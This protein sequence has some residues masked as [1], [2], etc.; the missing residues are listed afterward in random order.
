MKSFRTLKA[1]LCLLVCMLVFAA[2]AWASEQDYA[3]YYDD[4]RGCAV[5]NSYTGSETHV[6]VPDTVGGHTVL[7]VSYGVFAGNT[8]IISV[9]LPESVRYLDGGAFAACTSLETVY[10]PEN[11][12]EFNNSGESGFKYLVD[13]D[14][15]TAKLMLNAAGFYPGNRFVDPEYP[16]MKLYYTANATTGAAELGLYKYLAKDEETV[17]VPD[18]VMHIYDQAFIPEDYSQNT[19]LKEIHLPDS[20]VSIGS[21]VFPGYELPSLENIYLS[22]NISSW[23]AYPFNGHFSLR[24]YCSLYSTTARTFPNDGTGPSG[25]IDPA[26]PDFAWKSDGSG[27]RILARYYGSAKSLTIPDDVTAIGD[28]AFSSNT[29]LTTITVPDSVTSVGMGAFFFDFPLEQN[30]QGK[31]TLYLPDHITSIEVNSLDCGQT[32]LFVNHDSATAKELMRHNEE[33]GWG[34]L[35]PFYDPQYPDYLLGQLNNETYFLG[36]HGGKTDICIP[37]ICTVVQ[38]NLNENTPDWRNIR[39]VAIS[40]GVTRIEDHA[41]D[42]GWSFEFLSLPSTL[43]YIGSKALFA[44]SVRTLI[45]P[46]GVT[47][48]GEVV[49]DSALTHLVLPASLTKIPDNAFAKNTAKVTNVGTIYCYRGSYAETWAKA[50]PYQKIKYIEDLSYSFAFPAEPH[51]YTGGGYDWRSNTSIFPAKPDTPYTLHIES[52]NP[53]IVSV[54]N[55]ELILNA[56]GIA[57]LTVSSPELGVSSSFKLTVYASIEDFSLPEYIFTKVGTKK[58]TISASDIVPPSGT[59]P[60]YMWSLMRTDGGHGI[61]IESYVLDSSLLPASPDVCTVTATTRNSGL[62]RVCRLVV[63]STVNSTDFSPFTGR[64]AAGMTVQP[65]ITVT[66]D[67]I[68]Y[69][70][71][72]ATYT[73]TSSNTAVAKPTADG[74]LELLAPGTATITAKF[75]NGKTAKQTVTVSGERIYAIPAGVKEIGREAFVNCPATI[76]T[77][78]DSCTTIGE[79]AFAGSLS[80]HTVEIPESVTSIADNAFEGCPEDMTIIAPEDSFAAEYAGE[81]G[82]GE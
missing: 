12:I 23:G 51:A 81:H 67:D 21:A 17:S 61:T 56:P 34:V 57:T 70:N 55:D 78:P 45:I 74:K 62:S 22:E 8:S 49:V 13:K 44:T 54:E 65:D 38:S 1:A 20:V 39:S 53:N 10:L 66:V 43:R 18:S 9:T 14:S 75:L 40:E 25:F 15:A 63:Y 27:G 73:L 24:L 42:G 52:A 30:P 82:F 50:R 19:V 41:F 29:T 31:R 5:I 46:E 11:L 69:K 60:Q 6:T 7:D 36:Y 72:A 71:I 47:E 58:L 79:R 76:V 68:E 16:G 3:Y 64:T 2:P 33:W 59:D 4:S 28:N 26:D 32:T 37:P 35:F 77:I 48:V 80:L